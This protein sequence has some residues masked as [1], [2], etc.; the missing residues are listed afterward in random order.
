MK[1]IFLSPFIDAVHKI[2]KNL[3]RKGVAL[4]YPQDADEAWKML[5][6]H[7]KS[8][9]LVIGHVKGHLPQDPFLIFIE[10]VKKDPLHSDLPIILTTEQWSEAECATHQEGP[11]GANA[12]LR[13][14]WQESQLLE[15]VEAVVGPLAVVGPASEPKQMPSS[16]T[17]LVE[18]KEIHKPLGEISIRLEAPDLEDL[19]SDALKL[20]GPS[21]DLSDANV[22]KPAEPKPDVPPT[23]EPS[24]ELG[25]GGSSSVPSSS[26]E[27]IS[28]NK[29]D[30]VE[31]LELDLSG[32]SSI[33][34]V[35]E[36]APN[37]GEIDL[38]EISVAPADQP[39]AYAPNPISEPVLVQPPT[40]AQAPD[41]KED[42]QLVQE[43]PY[44]FRNSQS[45]IYSEA[46]GDAVVPGGVAHSP[47]METIKKYL[48]LREQDVA[49]L[50]NQLKVAQEE[51]SKAEKLIS[52]ERAK[53]SELT[54]L[55]NEK[56]KTI[57]QF[58]EEKNA[59]LD[60]HQR[61]REDLKFQIKT[62][63][64]QV[65]LQE[66]Q[67]KDGSDQMERLKDRV[68]IDIR[69]IRIREKELEN[70]LEIAKKDTMVLLSAR[71][72]KIIELKRKID[73]LEFNMDLIQEQFA[74]EKENATRL[75]ERLERAAQ[76][77]KVAMG[78]LETSQGAQVFSTITKNEPGES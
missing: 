4:L 59:L 11:A 63:S 51:I 31:A 19:H 15:T 23:E 56:E 35:G 12:Y 2:S 33:P 58:D 61:E 21:L 43:M 50:S 38:S 5:Q 75:R 27:P 74:R 39:E 9:D 29:D 16:E 6:L 46:I 13:S 53:N 69:K 25:F 68:R 45:S 64:D 78:L 73:L 8:V 26:S 18:T 41:Q 42:P 66:K 37:L 76:A 54:H 62:K 72:N 1:I 20:D 34:S 67:A 49:I 60:N 55:V 36:S 10:K 3:Q 52:S 47:D 14:P 70:Q 24:L 57:Q 32:S 7:G 77:H 40:A 22:P 65:R 28:L 71:E 44:L 48:L 17:I 30:A